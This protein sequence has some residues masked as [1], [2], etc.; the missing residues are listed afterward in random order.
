MDHVLL[1]LYLN[2]DSMCMRPWAL[3]LQVMESPLTAVPRSVT[4]T[5]AQSRSGKGDGGWGLFG[6]TRSLVNV[7]S[8]S[9]RLL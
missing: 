7:Q 8:L 9:S 6:G 5:A 3:C 1:Y 2:R 4:A